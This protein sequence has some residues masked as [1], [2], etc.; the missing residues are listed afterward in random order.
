MPLDERFLFIN[1]TKDNEQLI[2]KI[3]DNA[4]GINADI[5]ERIFEPYFTTKHK[6]QGTGL[7]LFICARIIIDHFDGN[8]VCKNVEINGEKGSEILI[9]LPI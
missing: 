2:I 6:F 1:V 3:F 5:I 9:T 7:G 4:Q 8:I